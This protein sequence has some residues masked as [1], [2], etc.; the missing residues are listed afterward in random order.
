MTCPRWTLPHDIACLTASC[1]LFGAWFY[2]VAL[3]I[4]AGVVVA[5]GAGTQELLLWFYAALA[6]LTCS[7]DMYN[8]LSFP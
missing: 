1:L 4:R 3:A 7:G 6:A 8:P 2:C 5:S